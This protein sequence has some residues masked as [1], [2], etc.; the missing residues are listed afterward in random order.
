MSDF[1][2][3]LRFDNFLKVVKSIIPKILTSLPFSMSSNFNPNAYLERLGVII[4]V[5]IS[6]VSKR[7]VKLVLKIVDEPRHRAAAYAKLGR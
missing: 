7:R 4:R 2:Y 3:N 6:V 5:G 1:A